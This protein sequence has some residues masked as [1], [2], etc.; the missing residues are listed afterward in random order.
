MA[1]ICFPEQSKKLTLST[2][3]T[4]AYVH[5]PPV[6][7]SISTIL[8]LHGFPS[9][10]YDWRHQISFFSKQGYGVLVPDLLGYGDT[11]KPTSA[12]EYRAK[13]MAGEISE[14][15]KHERLSQVHAVS[16]DT[17]SILLS[18]MA[19]YY[20]DLLRSCTFLAVPY[21]KPG[22][23]FDLEAI[24]AMTKG[25]L[26]KEKFGYLEFFVEEGAGQF[27]D[28]HV[29]IH[30]ASHSDRSLY[31]EL[32]YWYRAIPFSLCSIPKTQ[33]YGMITLAQQVL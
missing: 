7:P 32:I 17:G 15:L 3:N 20:P 2:N 22:D 4:Y 28:E 18:R 33:S 8:F 14:I 16:H 10:C 23:H 1:Y 21:S 5:I 12:Q 9:S 13:I 24:N 26:G 19:D 11:S 29:S 31:T 25:I 6:K 30:C 27:I